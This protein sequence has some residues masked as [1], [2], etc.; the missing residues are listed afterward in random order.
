MLIVLQLKIV[1][2]K[3]A[4]FF[5]IFFGPIARMVFLQM[6]THRHTCMHT[7]IHMHINHASI[8]T[9]QSKPNNLITEVCQALSWAERGT[10]MSASWPLAGVNK[11][12]FPL[13]QTRAAFKQTELCPRVEREV[14]SRRY[15]EG[16]RQTPPGPVMAFIWLLSCNTMGISR[17]VIAQSHSHYGPT[18]I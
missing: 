14:A 6:I 1:F 16:C 11:L 12:W 17:S 13:S 18:L 5:V 4:L 7:Y 3:T 15:T 2:T 10:R 9:A 8:W